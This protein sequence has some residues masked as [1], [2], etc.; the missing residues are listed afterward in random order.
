M[1]SMRLSPI[2]NFLNNMMKRNLFLL[3]G[4]IFTNIICSQSDALRKFVQD[5][6]LK[7]A[8]VG[9]CVTDLNTGKTILSHNAD[10]SFTP[11][12]VMKL[13]TTATA[14]EVLGENYRYTTQV[15]RD[16]DEPTRILILGSGDPTL[17]SSVFLNDANDFFIRCAG[18]LRRKLSPDSI[19]LLYVVDH[20]FGYDG[21]SSE[22][23]W[24]D[25]GNYY[26]AGS[27]GISVYDNSYRL[28][29]STLQNGVPPKI[30]RTE[31]IIKNL[32]FINMLSLNKSGR[33]NASI[34]G[35]PFSYQRTI[36]GDI[37]AGKSEFSIKGDI[38]DPGMYFGETL[39]DY[40]S[41]A[42]LNVSKTETSRYD[43]IANYQREKKRVAYKL[44]ETL[45]EYQ[46]HPMKDIIREVN[47]HS[48]NHYAE[49]LIRA[50][51]RYANADI[52]SNAL[53][54][55]T[56]F[57]VRYWASKNMPTSSLDMKDGCGLAP[58]NAVSPRLINDVLS[59]M[60]N[61]SPYASAFYAS[62]P[63]MGQEGTLRYFMRNSKYTGKISAK[64]GSIGGVQSY[65]GYLIDGHKKYAFTIMVNK[66]NG[67]ARSQVRNAIA[68]L[69]N[70]L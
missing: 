27:Y 10:K 43:Y 23:T 50:I 20:L 9:V 62:L 13:L 46:S 28:F 54:E 66:F 58:Q 68:E 39:S 59:Y 52:Y 61:K 21:I 36:T 12:S 49:H 15:T 32:S 56:N 40:L 17:G 67:A 14:I 45:F 47:V 44:G 69:L 55:G 60:L 41:N 29:F 37:P 16:A 18:E 53:S 7:H 6:S 48:N 63:K 33:D 25:M 22:W 70:S 11:A 57:V 1:N 65:A 8:S 3:L 34:N 4:L 26:A 31:P 51:G 19:Y 42:G 64:S 2:Y 35:M 30:L 38:P 24:Y 5:P